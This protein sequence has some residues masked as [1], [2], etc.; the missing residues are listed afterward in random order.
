M[1]AAAV[2][3]LVV[4]L[5]LVDRCASPLTFVTF[6]RHTDVLCRRVHGMRRLGDNFST[7]TAPFV[8]VLTFGQTLGSLLDLECPWPNLLREWMQ[9]LDIFNINLELARYDHASPSCGSA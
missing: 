4:V 7:L 9:M 3:M 1:V 5:V 2:L 8:I 6:C